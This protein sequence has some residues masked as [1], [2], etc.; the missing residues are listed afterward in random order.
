MVEHPT[1]ISGREQST[2]SRL[3]SYHSFSL[4]QTYLCLTGMKHHDTIGLSEQ[5]GGGGGGGGGW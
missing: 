2:A 3:R 1:H 5:G 4:Q